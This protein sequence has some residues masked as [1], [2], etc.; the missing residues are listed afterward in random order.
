MQYLFILFIY[1]FIYTAAFTTLLKGRKEKID[2]EKVWYG[3]WL[4]VWPLKRDREP[5]ICSAG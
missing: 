4:Q 2:R 3:A 1:L 5:E